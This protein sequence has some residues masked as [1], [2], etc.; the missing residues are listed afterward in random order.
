MPYFKLCG[1]TA[2]SG[3]GDRCLECHLA[4][5][6]RAKRSKAEIK[7]KRMKNRERFDRGLRRRSK[8]MKD[9]HKRRNAGILMTRCVIEHNGLFKRK[10]EVS[11]VNGKWDLFSLAHTYKSRP[12][13]EYAATLIGFGVVM[14]RFETVEETIANY[15]AEKRKG[16]S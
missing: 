8:Y 1:H 5:E 11:G 15:E 4:S 14:E 3:V 13:A 10:V 12:I 2:Y 7:S 16:E 9:Y 6:S